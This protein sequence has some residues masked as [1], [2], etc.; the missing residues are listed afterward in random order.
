MVLDALEE[1]FRDCAREKNRT[2]IRT[3]AITALGRLAKETGDHTIEA[4]ATALIQAEPDEKQRT[5]QRAAW[6]K[7]IK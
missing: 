1:R 3:D 5:K 4:C 2:L 6:R 7:A